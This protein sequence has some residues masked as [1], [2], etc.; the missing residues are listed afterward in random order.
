MAKKDKK[1]KRQS[2]KLKK[3]MRLDKSEKRRMAYEKQRQVELGTTRLGFWKFPLYGVSSS[4]I[5]E[6]SV[7]WGEWQRGER[8]D[9]KHIFHIDFA[10]WDL[11][12]EKLHIASY[13]TQ[14]PCHFGEI[15]GIAVAHLDEIYAENPDLE[16][17]GYKSVA[18]VRF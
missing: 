15:F 18:T 17:H 13:T 16:P 2:A 3:A 12:K 10:I 4:E 6:R 7:F 11:N 14:E 1:A 9:G 8:I 5:Y